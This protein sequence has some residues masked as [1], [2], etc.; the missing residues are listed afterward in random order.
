MLTNQ[1]NIPNKKDFFHIYN[2]INL[3]FYDHS[4]ILLFDVTIADFNLAVLLNWN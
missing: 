3:I 1:L 4:K 2:E